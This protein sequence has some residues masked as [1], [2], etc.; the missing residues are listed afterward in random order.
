MSTT[1]YH[2]PL[3]YLLPT[4][5]TTTTTTTNTN[6]TSI[7]TTTTTITTIITTPPTHP[8]HRPHQQLYPNQHGTSAP[9][10]T[11]LLNSRINIAMGKLFTSDTNKNL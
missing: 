10:G 8:H 9:R 5:T 6:T 3:F 2:L 7:T 4:A 1:H 11:W